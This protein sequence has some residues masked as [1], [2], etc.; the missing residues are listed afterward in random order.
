MPDVEEEVESVMDQVQE[1]GDDTRKFS[2]A[3]SAEFYEGVANACKLRARVIRE[4]MGE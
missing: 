1:V 3:E 4:E 2:Q